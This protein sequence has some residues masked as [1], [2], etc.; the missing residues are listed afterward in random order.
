[1]PYAAHTRLTFSGIFGTVTAPIEGW[2]FRLN[3]G[4]MTL[5]AA[6]DQLVAAEAAWTTHLAPRINSIARLQEVKLASIGVDGRYTANPFIRATDVAGTSTA[7]NG[8]PLQIAAVVSLVTAR[9]GSSG[10]GRFYVPAPATGTEFASRLFSNTGA[11]ELSASAAAFIS[12]LN[13]IAGL[14]DVVVASSKGVNSVVTGVR[15]GRVPDTIRSRRRSL[16]EDYQP[17]SAVTTADV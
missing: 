14:S 13:G 6:D 3:M 8:W 2:A 11:Q 15:V 9:R 1:M 5:Q 7:N 4:P 16:S 10:R 17:T 12:A